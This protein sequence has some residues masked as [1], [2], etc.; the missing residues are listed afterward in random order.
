MLNHYFELVRHY[1]KSIFMGGL[2]AGV[3]AFVL[4]AIWLNTRP[5]F[6]STVILNMQPS[7]E[8][9]RF[10]KAF[11]GVSQFNPATIIAQTHVERLLSRPVAERA[12]DI[13]IEESGGSLPAP[14]PTMLDA[15]R[16]G[17]FRS[18]NTLNYG[19]HTTPAE[20]QVLISDLH[21]ATEIEIVEGSY[22]LN[23]EVSHYNPELAAR[24]ANALGRAYIEQTQADVLE[25]SLAVDASL[26][27]VLE[28]K[29]TE[30][31]RLN[32]ER[33]KAALGM[34]I[35]NL[36]VE[37]DI[38]LESRRK[39]SETLSEARINEELF[40]AQIESL[41]SSIAQETNVAA[42]QRMR[43]KIAEVRA[44][45]AQAGE[46]IEL[47]SD[48]LKTIQA[49]LSKLGDAEGALEDFDTAIAAVKID[50]AELRNRR[51]LVELA[52][53]AQLSQVRIIS[54]A[55]VATYPAA[56]KVL[57]NTIIGTILGALAVMVAMSAFDVFDKRLRSTDD[58]SSLFGNRV[59]PPISRGLAA[60]AGAF[61]RRGN[62]PAKYLASY[63]R[64]IWQRFVT[65]PSGQWPPQ[66]IYVTA[67]GEDVDVARLHDVVKSAAALQSTDSQNTK[68]VE[69][70]MLPVVSKLND[71]PEYR[72]KH[73]VIGVKAGSI[74]AEEIENAGKANGEGAWGPYLVVMQ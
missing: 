60:K 57:L 58:L 17:F 37:R 63:S 68:P 73:L 52:R 74:E 70:R 55:Q 51:A 8:E 3:L 11:L 9:L 28:Q 10:S 43:L 46:R 69:I 53:E 35:N 16:A 30:L 29:E 49:E 27:N 32:G 34:G 62:A 24:A 18:W 19:Y 4:S 44:A 48:S 65:D 26:M 21:K 7:E 67:F 22:I 64:N 72:D 56:P 12:I 45:L 2:I 31:N 1:S 61:L 47:R 36:S 40:T 6:Q 66:Q 59:L 15:L 25:A 71:W 23:L 39:A 38:L 33:R 5:V 42:V 54:P 41:K 20:R 50:L 14:P 13:L